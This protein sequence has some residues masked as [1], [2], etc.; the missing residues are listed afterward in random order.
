MIARVGGHGFQRMLAMW[1]RGSLQ[2]TVT[3]P[4]QVSYP[5][6]SPA[7]AV[8]FRIATVQKPVQCASIRRECSDHDEHTARLQRF[9]NTWFT[10]PVVEV[11]PAFGQPV[12]R[13]VLESTLAKPVRGARRQHEQTTDVH[14]ARLVF[15]VP[16]QFV[17]APGATIV[18][19]PQRTPAPRDPLRETGKALHRRS[20][21][22]HALTTVNWSISARKQLTRPLHQYARGL[23]RRDQL[24]AANVVDACG[25]CQP[26]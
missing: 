23:H 2:V 8:V 14:G 26:S 5:R 15:D 1:H 22:R 9:M 12:H 7:F 17:T 19:A 3:D 6:R 24:D 4:K 20:R 10:P 13:G 21:C 25:A 16:E 18:C 11:A